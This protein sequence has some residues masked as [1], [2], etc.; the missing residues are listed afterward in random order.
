MFRKIETLMETLKATTPKHRLVAI[1]LEEKNGM[2]HS[3]VIEI[4]R[5]RDQM[6]RRY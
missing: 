1:D 3:F 2:G 5:V 4:Q 6:V